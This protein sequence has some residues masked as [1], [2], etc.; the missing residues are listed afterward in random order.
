MIS[1][2]RRLE[3]GC[4]G[5]GF[6]PAGFEGYD[7]PPIYPGG[8]QDPVKTKAYIKRRSRPEPI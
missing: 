5:V 4:V 7:E 6:D 1:S 2:W 3:M 8:G